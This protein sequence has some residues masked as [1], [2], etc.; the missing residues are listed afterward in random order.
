[1]RPEAQDAAQT[2]GAMVRQRRF[3]LSMTVEE[4]AARAGV[5]PR[6]VSQ[7]EKGDGSV[8]IGNVFNVAAVIGVP[9]FG[10][11]DA[12]TLALVSAR[13]RAEANSGGRTRA[14]KAQVVTDAD[15]DF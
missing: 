3:A 1:M 7:V 13:A 4:L 10:A 11:D 9:L 8:S 15:V 14:R 5:S 6:T 2:I 12:A